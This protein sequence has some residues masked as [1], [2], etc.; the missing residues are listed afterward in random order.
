MRIEFEEVVA[1]LAQIL[2][3]KGFEADDAALSARLFAEASRD[4][5]ASHGLNRFAQYADAIDRREIDPAAR[6][7]RVESAGAL[8]RWDG[9]RGP[10]NLNAWRSMHRAMQLADSHGIGSVALS[11]TNHW[12]RGGA[13][14]RQAAE[15]GYIGICWTNTIGNLPPWGG[16]EPKLGNNPMILAVPFAGGPIVHDFAMSQYSYGALANFRRAD[17][18]LPFPGGFDAGGRLTTDP[19]EI[20]RTQRPLPIGMW[21]GSGLA[22]MLDLIASLLSGGDST[23]RI[24]RRDTEREVSQLFIAIRIPQGGETGAAWAQTLVKEAID[25]LH[26]A[27]PVSP[28]DPV[29]YPGE[30]VIESRR[31]AELHGVEVDEAIWKAIVATKG[32]TWWKRG[33]E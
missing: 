32:G 17:R 18:P 1:T 9:R 27:T 24:S 20:E 8:E 22:L 13:Y 31:D 2:L 10:G 11:R 5:V 29:R 30:R 16:I 19:A 6:P 21:K 15:A 7:Q 26:G 33:M 12:M 4:G 3:E 28:G 23:S 25:D 14:G